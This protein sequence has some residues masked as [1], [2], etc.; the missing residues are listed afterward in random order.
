MNKKKKCVIYT[1]KI[2]TWQNMMNFEDFVASN[3]PV[4]KQYDSLYMGLV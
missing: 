1:K 4:T 3:K 2:D